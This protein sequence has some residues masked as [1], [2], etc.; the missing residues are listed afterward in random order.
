MKLRFPNIYFLFFSLTLSSAIYPSLLG[1]YIGFAIP[2][3]FATFILDELLVLTSLFFMGVHLIRRPQIS[4][5][6]GGYGTFLIA[7]LIFLISFF[8]LSFF[9]ADN[10][11][12]IISRDRWIVI[13]ALILLYPFVYRPSI[14]DLSLLYKRLGILVALITFTK[15]LSLIFIGNNYLY[16]QFGPSFLFLASLLLAIYLWEGNNNLLKIIFSISLVSASLLGQQLS[17]LL[18]TIFCILIPIYLLIFKASLLPLI[19]FLVSAGIISLY[20][21]LSIDLTD[22]ILFFQLNPLNFTFIDK[23][24]VYFDLW[25]SP[26]KDITLLEILFGKGAGYSTQVLTYNEFSQEY[27]VVNHS[28]AHNFLVTIFMKFGLVGLIFISWILFVIFS[29]FSRRF[30]FS[31]SDVFK[32]LLFLIVL[33]FL[34]TPG[35]WKLRKGFIFWFVIGSLY[36]FRNYKN[37]RTNAKVST[38]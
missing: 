26:L 23:L 6:I 3:G 12:E 32:I 4:S 15:Y 14:E 33:N 1:N 28:L 36:F 24:I 8:I 2:L 5:N 30:N 31:R 27:S 21:S 16:S 9:R 13:N 10:S 35:I 37:T 11:L 7:F 38:I 18:L 19:F 29:P 25:F 20:V 17:S 22:I 34:S